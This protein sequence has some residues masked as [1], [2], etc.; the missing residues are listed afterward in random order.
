MKKILSLVLALL[1]SASVATVGLAAGTTDTAIAST[2]SAADTYGE[3]IAVLENYGIMKGINPDTFD[4]DAD[5]DI[6]RYQM[7]LFTGRIATGWIYDT[8]WT[9]GGVNNS[10]FTDLDG[11]PAASFYGAISYAAQKGIILGYGDGKFGPT[12]G[13]KYKDALTMVLRTLEYTGLNYPWGFIEKAESLGLTKG[14]TGVAYDDILNR[15]EVA[16]IIYNALFITTKNT[17]DTLGAR[18]FGGN[19]GWKTIIVSVTDRAVVDPAD[20]DNRGKVPSGAVGFRVVAADGT[21]E[22]TTYYIA[23]KYLGIGDGAHDDE[24]VLGAAYSALFT[25]DADGLVRSLVAKPLFV[26]NVKNYGL[27]TKDTTD[28]KYPIEKALEGLSLVSKFGKDNYV[29]AHSWNGSEIIIKNALGTDAKLTKGD[30]RYAIDWKTGDILV[31][32]KDGEIEVTF[33]EDDVVKYSVAWYYNALLGKYF[34]I[35][36]AKV[37]GGDVEVVGINILDD[38]SELGDLMTKDTTSGG[39]AVLNKDTIKKATAYANLDLYSLA[40]TTTA[41]YGLYTRY[42]FGQYKAESEVGPNKKAGFSITTLDAVAKAAWEAYSG[43]PFEAAPTYKVMWEGVDG[44]RTDD[45]AYLTGEAVE[46]GDY[47][48]YSYNEQ[49]GELNIFKNITKLNDK[50][51]FVGTGIVR[52][53]NLTKKTVTIGD[54]EYSFDYDELLGNG[55][56]LNADKALSRAA[57]GKLLGDS[58]M[59]FVNYVVCDGKLVW[60]SGNATNDTKYIIVD[61]FAGISADGYIVVNGY[62]SDALKYTQFRIGAYDQWLKGDLYNYALN[63]DVD[64]LFT[65][66]SV[67]AVSSYDKGN[68]AYY[69]KTIAIANANTVVNGVQYIGY[70]DLTNTETYKVEFD[71]NGY[72][73][74][75]IGG[76]DKG[77]KRASSDD[78]YVFLL[79]RPAED[80]DFGYAPIVVYTGKGN[81]N[82]FV[83][84]VRLKG[85]NIIIVNPTN[86]IKGFTNNQYAVYYGLVVSKSYDSASYTSAYDATGKELLGAYTSTVEVVNLYTGD[87]KTVKAINKS[88][89]VGYIYPVINGQITDDGSSSAFGDQY[90]EYG[91]ADLDAGKL[92]YNAK[93]TAYGYLSDTF[94]PD[95]FDKEKFSLYAEKALKT[96]K[97]KDGNVVAYKDGL[98]GGVK[99]MLVSIS[100]DKI[101][102]VDDSFSS[103]DYKAWVK[104]YDVKSCTFT[105]VLHHLG[106]DDGSAIIYV[107]DNPVKNDKTPEDSTSTDITGTKLVLKTDEYGKDVILT[108][109]V[110]SKVTTNGNTDLVTALEITGITLAYGGDSKIVDDSSNHDYYVADGFYF[111][112]GLECDNLNLDVKYSVDGGTEFTVYDR[113]SGTPYADHTTGGTDKKNLKSITIPVAV[114]VTGLKADDTGVITLKITDSE[115]KTSEIAITYTVSADGKTVAFTFATNDQNVRGVDYTY[116]AEVKDADGKVTTP[117][118][119]T[120][121]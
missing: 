93:K 110:A 98:N 75:T 105:A 94:S 20:K 120:K 50:D 26:K 91:V 12:D 47:V 95:Y 33:G 81:E 76:E 56:R 108:G 4:A 117:A 71:N 87:I 99:V 27:P 116:N 86:G 18:N 67:Y 48:I 69:V 32:D 118:K 40:G 61:S 1:M 58:F 79:Q 30:H 29:N 102:V 2:P 64:S 73:H 21:L 104:K 74:E 60:I 89:A 52:A 78:K 37:S 92:L 15:G 3:A 63:Y 31:V 85:T 45:I 72:K 11:T 77:W 6:Q 109:S 68:D 16:Q 19:L 25:T 112:K 35:K 100:G 43:D 49:T 59:N 10:G 114:K 39:L 55:M 36:T 113:V 51:N 119:Y 24:A 101:T 53:Y 121:A 23:R 42:A 34:Q 17:G 70:K 8:Q 107:L 96:F 41:D 90:G 65:K 13:I 9:N 22:D 97:D 7:A 111:G 106:K 62:A 66:G 28:G 54:K 82:W 5:S 80:E 84:G 14:I 44:D 57:Y 38:V 88:V 115:G 103:D 83:D 46:S